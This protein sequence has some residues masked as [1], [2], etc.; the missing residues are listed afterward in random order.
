MTPARAVAGWVLAAV[1]ACALAL[2]ACGPDA[3]DAAA[4]AARP[5]VGGATTAACAWPSVVL[6]GDSCTGALVHPRLVVTAAHCVRDGITQ[7]SF[8]ENDV[9][10]ARVVAISRCVANPAYN[11]ND[12]DDVGF[13]LLGEDVTGV[14]LVRVM[15][16]CEAGALAAGGAVIEVGFGQNQVVSGTGDGFGVKRSLAAM[17]QGVTTRGQIDVTT[18]SQA[19]EYFGDSGGPL[20]FDLPDHTWRLVGDDCCGPTIVQGSTAARRSIYTSIAAEVAWLE[21]ASG[22]DLTPCH[23]ATGWTPTADCAAFPTN[24]DEGTGTWASSCAGQTLVTPQP[25][26]GG[27]PVDASAPPFVDA[28]P[29]AD[30]AAIDDASAEPDAGTTPR[31]HSS[32]CSCTASSPDSSPV[33]ILVVVVVVLLLL[34]V[35]NNRPR[36]RFPS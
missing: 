33:L 26:C 34:L 9:A 23:D 6:A 35:R 31:S 20:F 22:L 17:I 12:T 5:I 24:P 3:A 16:A 8:G 30:A 32:G 15:A 4:A 28:T 29:T 13:C 21:T 1:L 11:G 25:T 10:P 19:G 27:Q 18:G 2:P 36:A 14:P 7:I